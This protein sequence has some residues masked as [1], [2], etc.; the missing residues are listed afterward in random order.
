MVYKD[1]E[2]LKLS[3]KK[4]VYTQHGEQM[5]AFVTTDGVE[6]WVAFADK[7][8]HTQII[9][10]VDIEY[11]PEQLVRFEEVKDMEVAETVLNDYIEVGL[12]GDGLEKIKIREQE[13]IINDL[14]TILAD[15]G[16]IY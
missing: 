5:E 13:K 1:K 7:W 4:V 6:W 14:V 16:V 8:D 12:I 15:K 11:T 2:G 9:E 10:I 3:K